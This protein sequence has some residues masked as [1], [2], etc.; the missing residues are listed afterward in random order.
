[1]RALLP[2]ALQLI[3]AAI[4]LAAAVLLATRLPPIAVNISIIAR[5]ITVSGDY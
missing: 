2:C 5:D 4:I 3:A 1:V